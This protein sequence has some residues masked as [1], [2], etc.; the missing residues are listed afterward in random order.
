MNLHEKLIELHETGDREGIDLMLKRMK[1][2][3]DEVHEI[4]EWKNDRGVYD[5]PN[6]TILANVQKNIKIV[7]TFLSDENLWDC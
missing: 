5:W 6:Q 3:R 1:E 4:V 2:I 7:E